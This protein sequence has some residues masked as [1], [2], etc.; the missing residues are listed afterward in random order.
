[1]AVS[2]SIISRIVLL[3][4]IVACKMRFGYIAGGRIILSG[5]FTVAIRK[6]GE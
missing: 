3:T 6:I 4:K 1:M 2:Y 5:S